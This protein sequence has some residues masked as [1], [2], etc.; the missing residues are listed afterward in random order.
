MSTLHGGAGGAQSRGI[1]I[2]QTGGRGRPRC[3]PRVRGRQDVVRAMTLQ[4]TT[5]QREEEERE[6]E[7]LNYCAVMCA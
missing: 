7:R 3:Y 4:G 1:Q 2:A 6:R 5:V